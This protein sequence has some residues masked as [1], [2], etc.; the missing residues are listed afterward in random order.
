MDMNEVRRA[1]LQALINQKTQGNRTRF[2]ELLGRKQSYVS[3]ILNGKKP[4]GERVARS[5]EVKM[6]LPNRWLDQERATAE[7]YEAGPDL[8]A[9]IRRLPIM[10]TCTLE[11]DGSWEKIFVKVGKGEGYIEHASRDESAY[12]IRVKGNS[13][14]PTIRSGWLVVI[15]PD[16]EYVSGNFVMLCLEEN[17]CLIRELLYTKDEE[18]EVANINNPAERQTLDRDKV[19]GIYLVGAIVP[20]SKARMYED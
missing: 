20:F 5:I 8:P 14:S 10:G 3:D 18:I 1:N 15:E 2:G 7:E 16:S 19:K 11:P 17:K 12:T 9:R 4:F 6:G 13:L